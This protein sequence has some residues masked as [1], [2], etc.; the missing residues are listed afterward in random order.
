MK[1]IIFL[2]LILPF[3]TLAQENRTGKVSEAITAAKTI[4][5][6]FQS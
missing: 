2:V 4:S 5:G 3:L 6:E 1:K